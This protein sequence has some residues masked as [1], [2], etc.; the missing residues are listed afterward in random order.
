MARKNIQ[1]QLLPEERDALLKWIFIPEVRSQ[2]EA[3]ASRDHIV[4][5]TVTPTDLNW[6]AS[7]LTHA[8]VK[9][10]CRDS[11]VVDLSERLEYVYRVARRAAGELVLVTARHPPSEPNP[12]AQVSPSPA[13]APPWSSIPH[14]PSQ[15]APDATLTR[16]PLG[17]ATITKTIITSLPPSDARPNP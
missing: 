8:I 7:D 17:S 4:S 9:K 6:M 16:V 2:L 14:R 13:G 12:P 5:I 3:V 1:L 10:G 11:L 15:D